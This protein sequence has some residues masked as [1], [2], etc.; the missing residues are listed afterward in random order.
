M[1]HAL[2]TLEPL[3]AISLLGFLVADTLAFRYRHPR[4]RAR[5]L[6]QPSGALMRW[7]CRL[8]WHDWR[9]IAMH[10]PGWVLLTCSRCGKDREIRA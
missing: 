9:T 6:L 1:G 3:E 5:R 4:R 7:L 10:R 8:G 2:G